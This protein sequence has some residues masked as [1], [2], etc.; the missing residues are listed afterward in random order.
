LTKA[1]IHVESDEP[2][3]VLV[4]PLPPRKVRRELPAARQVVET[5]AEPVTSNVVELRRAG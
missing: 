2:V 4:V 5:T 3:M 1:T